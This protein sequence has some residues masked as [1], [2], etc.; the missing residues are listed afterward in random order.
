MFL[1]ILSTSSPKLL[2]GR[3]LLY[4]RVSIEGK[5]I[6][7]NRENLDVPLSADTVYES[8]SHY[9]G[10]SVCF[11]FAKMRELPGRHNASH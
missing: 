3:A 2:V 9:V 5:S 1:E 4:E 8:L 6:F 11:L 7:F 10:R